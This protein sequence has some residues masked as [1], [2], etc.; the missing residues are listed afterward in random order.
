MQ[1][2]VITKNLHLLLS[3]IIVVFVA[4]IYGFQPKLLFDVAIN[5]VDEANIFKAIMTLYLGFSILWILGILKPT[6]WKMATVSNMI[7][8][9]SIA[10]GRFFSILSDGLPSTL[11][12]VGTLGEFVLGIY[13]GYQLK[14]ERASLG[15][16]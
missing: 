9:L 5:S 3:T 16:L 13:A 2:K 12:V 15:K 8:M 11:F 14:K 10:F 4:F 6:Y 7:F 1:H